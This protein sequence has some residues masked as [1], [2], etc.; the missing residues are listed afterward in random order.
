[1]K[2]KIFAVSD[3]HGHY[4]E[5]RSALDE[6][7]FSPDNDGHLLIVCGDCFDRGEENRAVLEYLNSV[8]N[9]ILIKG[10]HEDMLRNALRTEQITGD[11]V[12]NSLDITL[13]EFFGADVFDRRGRLNFIGKEDILN[14]LI[15]H[16]DGMCDYFETENYL[17]THGWLPSKYA[18]DG[19][20]VIEGYRHQ[21]PDLWVRGR[22]TPWTQMYTEGA[23]LEGKTIVCGHRA[24]RY[25]SR[26]D[27]SRN[28]DDSHVF[29]GNG[30]IA[31]DALTV[32]SGRVNVLML[33]DDISVQTHRMNLKKEPS[34]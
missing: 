27:P 15:R 19:F 3:I 14:A 16:I 1:M 33:E 6:A 24:A 29:Y 4:T 10:N 2:K 13:M 31:I 21:T 30:M 18:K 34:A 26:F 25:G 9:K 28:A 5:M 23:T 17:F 7:G 20:R 32:Q 22:I 12:Y 11:D 8:Q